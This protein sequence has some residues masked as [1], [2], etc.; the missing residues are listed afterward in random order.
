MM[1]FF[2][3]GIVRKDVMGK[4]NIRKLFSRKM[5]EMYRAEVPQYAVLLDLVNQVNKN[6]L[7]QNDRLKTQLLDTNNLNRILEERH[8]AIRLGTSEELRTVCSL[9]GVMGMYPVGYYDL[10][11]AHMPVHATAFRPLESAALQE[12]PFRIFTSLLRIDLI[13]DQ[14]IVALIRQILSKRDIFTDRVREL[15][16]IDKKQNGLTESE[17]IEFVDEALETFRWHKR[18]SVSHEMYLKLSAIHPLVADIVAFR[19]PHINHLTPRTLDIDAVQTM[20]KEYGIDPKAII[21]GPPSRRT[22]VLLRQTSFK[23][24]QESIVFPSSSGDDVSGVHRARFGEIEQRGVALKPK[25]LALYHQITDKVREQIEPKQDG[26]N[27]QDYY[28]ILNHEVKFLDDDLSLLRK[29]N[30]VYLEYRP[31]QKGIDAAGTLQSSDL[32][33]LISEGYITFAPI[34]YEDFLPVSAAGI[35]SSNLGDSTLSIS[36]GSPDQ[37]AFEEAL[38]EKT[39]NPFEWYEKLEKESI[40]KSLGVLQVLSKDRELLCNSMS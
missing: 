12:N 16:A 27:A 33:V 29:E 19:G 22:P 2:A 39:I 18:A 8:G 40:Q 30:R 37:T 1:R 11:V 25:G 3:G 13:Q 21:E 5:S 15:I 34:V 26:S 28:R 20:M 4:D 10:S 31:T 17:A 32:E 23:A 38:G 14:E 35:F 6:T 24:L 36:V 9:F 7:Q